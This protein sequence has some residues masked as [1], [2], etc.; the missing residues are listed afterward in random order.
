M[1]NKVGIYRVSNPKRLA[2]TA[3][4]FPQKPFFVK[5]KTSESIAGFARCKSPKEVKEVLDAGYYV[6]KVENSKWTLVSKD[7]PVPDG[8][9]ILRMLSMMEEGVVIDPATYKPFI[10]DIDGF[11]TFSF[12]DF[13]MMVTRKN[14]MEKGSVKIPAWV[15][16][17]VT[18]ATKMINGRMGKGPA[19]SPFQ[20]G[21]HF[22]SGFHPADAGELVI[23]LP[24][25]VVIFEESKKLME[26]YK[27]MN[28]WAVILN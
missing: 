26:I 24:N 23:V 6:V 10:G 13:A 18:Q 1:T 11:D 5:A 4:R 2:W 20:H 21:Y 17:T 14:L 25:G 28:R 16:D 9:N 12:S 22:G 7:G 15:N 27:Q 8:D 3:R 19:R